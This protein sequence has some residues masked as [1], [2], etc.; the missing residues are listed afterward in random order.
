MFKTNEGMIDRA[1][2][3]IV[4]LVLLA[5]FFM[6]P[7]ASWRYWTLVGIIPLVT[8]LVGTCPVYSV[9]GISTCPTRKA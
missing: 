7:D 9:F 2:R 5:A 4:G 8:G 6:Y 3:V 1:I